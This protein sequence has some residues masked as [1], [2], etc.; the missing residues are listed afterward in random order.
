M[1]FP[2][3][4]SLELLMELWKIKYLRLVDWIEA[5]LK[6]QLMMS[7][8]NFFWL[9]SLRE[10]VSPFDYSYIDYSYIGPFLIFRS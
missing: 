2:I 5:D 10:T 8:V 1:P 9:F 6:I 7:Y 3:V 4:V